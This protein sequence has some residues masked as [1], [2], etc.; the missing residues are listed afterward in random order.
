[1]GLLLGDLEKVPQNFSAKDCYTGIYEW[2]K[3]YGKQRLLQVKREVLEDSYRKAYLALLESL[4]VPNEV[5]ESCM[6][7]IFNEVICM[8]MEWSYHERDEYGIKMGAYAHFAV[9]KRYKETGNEEF[10]KSKEK[11]FLHAEFGYPKWK[12]RNVYTTVYMDISEDQLR[13]KIAKEF[14]IPEGQEVKDDLLK[15]VLEFFKKSGGE[16]WERTEYPSVPKE[17]IALMIPTTFYT[18]NIIGVCT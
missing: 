4:P 15:A 16:V 5:S 2:H 14:R 13:Q 6:D 9:S 11:C 18:I 8:L 12:E 7:F 17:T 1:M 10:K 3:K